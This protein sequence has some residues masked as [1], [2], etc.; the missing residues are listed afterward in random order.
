LKYPFC[1]AA[2]LVGLGFFCTAGATQPASHTGL[3]PQ[4]ELATFH[5]APGFRVELVACEPN[6]IDPVAVSFDADGRMYV[7]EMPGYPNGG[8]ATGPVKSGKVKLL[9]DRDGDGF[10]EHCRTFIDGLRLPTSAMPWKDGVLVANPPDL[11]YYRDT[12]GEG[13]A[14]LRRLLYTGF[15]VENCEQLINGLQWGLDNWVYGCAASPGGTIRSAEKP[16]QPPVVL[17]NRAVRFQPDRPASLEPTSGGG[18]YGLASDDWEHWF[19][20]TN[21]Q[22][23]RHVVLPDHYLR[24]NP[25]LAIREVTLDIPDHGAACKVYRLSPFEAW[26]VERTRRRREGPGSR[27]YPDT[28]LVPGGFVTSGCSPIVYTA[29]L[30]SPPYRGNSFICDPANNLIHRDLLAPQGATFVARRADADR[31]FLASTDPWFRPVHLTLGPDGALYVTDFYREVIETPL[32]LP[33]D[34]QKTLNLESCG[35]GRIWRIVPQ[36]AQREPQPKLSQAPAA[37]LV[38]HLANP[39]SWWRLTAQ[40]LLIEKQDRS[41]APALR[42]LAREAATPQGRVHALWTLDGLHE[43]TADLVA[44][45]LKDPVPEVREQA[46]RLADDRLAADAGL[47]SAVAALADDPSA[48]LRFQ[49]A[50]TL[51]QAAAPELQEALAH[52]ALRDIEDLW[53]QT[54]VLSSAAESASSLLKRLVADRS[55]STTDSSARLQFLH[56][57]AAL[58]GARA[59][60]SELLSVFEML[61]P[62]SD[63]VHREGPS[64]RLKNAILE[65]LAEGMQNTPRRLS[66]L[67]RDPPAALGPALER[68]RPLFTRAAGLLQEEKTSMPERIAAARLLAYG[69]FDAAAPALETS[70]DPRQPADLQLAAVRALSLQDD[71]SVGRLLLRSWSAYS[72]GARREVLEAVFARRDRLPALLQALQER[73]IIAG[74][75]EPF[76]LQQLRANPDAALRARASALLAGVVATDRQKVVDAYRPALDLRADAARGKLIFKKTCSTCHRLENV[77][78][79]VGPDLLSA[80]RNK[81]R[82]QLLVDLFDPSRE[83]DPRYINYLVMTKPGRVFS[84]LIAAETATSVTLR[85]AEKAEDTILRAEI[86]EIQATAKSLMPENLEQQLTKQ[87]AADVIAYLQSVAAPK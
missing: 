69:P 33:E 25:A 56:R 63:V 29:D 65:G 14:D 66:R 72:P 7:T 48:H 31:E 21:A 35:K 15:S 16:D 19:V 3:S 75:L 52:V 54:A 74:Q 36:G 77:G 47:R 44:A 53:T 82:D 64:L 40:R 8:V 30:F 59:R 84:G 13:R 5:V 2:L 41:V 10:Y 24:R 23:L 51:G 80:L 26:R 86:E 87:D 42:N 85:R 62:A 37:E 70:L 73:K 78:V 18:Q 38:T 60:D 49:L 81:T 27:R 79:E 61:A 22:H 9:V 57:L 1:S 34:F 32:S 28:E 46:L 58:V 71:P 55:M 76:R 4:Q 17:H 68:L 20:N 11:V 12:R 83:V 39:N 50:F 45:A 67:W 43:L 6:V